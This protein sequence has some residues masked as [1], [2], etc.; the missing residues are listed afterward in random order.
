MAGTRRNLLASVK[1]EADELVPAR[2][3]VVANGA[4][5]LEQAEAILLK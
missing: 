1:I 3:V 4:F 2:P 5:L